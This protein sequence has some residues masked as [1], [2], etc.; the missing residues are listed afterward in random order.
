MQNS[1]FSSSCPECAALRAEVAALK[2]LVEGLKQELAQ[3]QEQLAK[4]TRNSF[5]SSKPPSSDIVKPPK[6]APKKRGKRRRGG[7]PGHPRYEHHFRPEEIDVTHTHRLEACP[8]CQGSHLV[9]LPGAEQTA[10]QYELVERPILLHAHQR[11]AGW[12]AQ[13]NQVHFAPLSDPVEKGGVVGPRLTALIGYLKGGCHLSYRNLQALLGDAFAVRLCTG[14]LTKTIQKV[15]AALEAPY[16]QLGSTL[17]QQKVC[18]IDETSHPENRQTLWNWVFRAPTFTLFTIETSRGAE[19]LEKAL[20]EE[21]EAVLGHDYYSAY[22]A[23]MKR[24]PVTVQFC[25]AHLIREARFLAQSSDAVIANYGQRVLEGLKKIFRLIHRRDQLKPE[26]F[27]RKIEQE[28]DAFLTMARRTRAGGE[29]ATLAQRFRTHGRQYFTFITDPDIE[30]TNNVAERALR[31]CV[32]DR[33]LTQ[34]TR[35]LLGR[36]WCERVWTT[37][38]T[39]TQ[40]GRSAFQFIAQAVKAHFTGMPAPSLLTK[41]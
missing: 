6:S 33:R 3:T 14:L 32:I 34:G 25:L 15:S 13:C 39:C 7:Q 5:N 38:A 21:C 8:Q 9:P 12:C 37:I 31:F 29:A 4:A 35:S 16:V 41:T 26:N 30:P 11:Q 18:N 2:Q 19:V 10:Y 24:A 23:Y 17:P 36:Q 1:S 22:R 20:G 40:Q 27:Q 28:R